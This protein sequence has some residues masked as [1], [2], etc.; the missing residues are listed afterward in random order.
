MKPEGSA[1][2]TKTKKQ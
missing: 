1:K 2:N